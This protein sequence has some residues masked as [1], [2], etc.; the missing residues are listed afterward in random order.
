MLLL[1]TLTRILPTR[2]AV[3][4]LTWSSAKVAIRRNQ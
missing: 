1:S 3:E 4:T 2:S